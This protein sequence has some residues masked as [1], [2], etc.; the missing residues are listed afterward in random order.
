MPS[1]MRQSGTSLIEQLE[2]EPYRFEF[3]QALRLLI[4]HQRQYS[5]QTDSAILEQSIRFRNSVSLGFPPSEIE[6]LELQWSRADKPKDQL[7]T[8][9]EGES[10]SMN[11]EVRQ[12][13]VGPR[14]GG[15][16]PKS[17][18]RFQ[19]AILTPAFMGL[20]GPS[21]VLPRHYTQQ[22]SDRMLYH[23]DTTMRAFLDIFTSRAVSLFY[24]SWTKYRL[25][26]Q[27]ES[28]RRNRFVPLVLSLGGLGSGSTRDRLADGGKGIADESLAY[29]VAAIRGR[30]RS[31]QWFARVVEDYFKVPARTTEFVGQWMSVPPEERTR[32]G[33]QHAVL[34]RSALCGGQV[35]DRQSRIR[36]T[37]GPMRKTRLLEMLP[38][39]PGHRNLARLFRLMQGLAY[40][41]E[42]RLILDR[43]DVSG[44][45]LQTHD[46]GVRLGWVSWLQTPTATSDADD[47][48]YLLGPDDRSD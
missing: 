46:D 29:Y 28:D 11:P 27:Y 21:G 2:C 6:S 10:T 43:C 40:D 47:A 15:S 34:G 8:V 25:H 9:P 41:C 1:K 19:K 36:L 23:R 18:D 44:A 3:F 37:L 17:T 4:A 31:A 5:G 13:S 33:L 22:V 24:Q 20:I 7:S 12:P 45:R 48:A 16:R 38:G 35:W 39:A 14:E 26:L 30:P 32:L 42:V